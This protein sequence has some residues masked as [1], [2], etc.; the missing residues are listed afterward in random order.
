LKP[1]RVCLLLFSLGLA[2]C[3]AGR[4]AKSPAPEPP[5]A[6]QQLAEAM[7]LVAEKNWPQALEALRTIIEGKS[8]G[9]LSSDFRYKA[10]SAAGRVA[11]YHGP[12]ELGYEYLGRVVALPQ[13]N[14]VDW[15]ERLRMA[16]KLGRKADSI[17]TLTALIRRWP[18]RAEE[19][20][21]DYIL[22]AVDDA[23]LSGHAAA[24]GLL[25]ALNAA[26]WKLKWDIEPSAAWRDLAL[27]LL[28]NKR[29][30][31][32]NE[33]AHHVTDAYVLIAMRSDRRFDAVVAANPVQFDIEAAADRE[34][35]GRQ[36]AAEK[37][38]Q[39]LKLRFLVIDSLLR[40]QHYE[41]ALAASDSILLD[42]RSTNYPQRLY[43]DY[44]DERPWFLNLRSIALQRVGRWDEAV[45]QLNA[46]SLLL[47]KY[48]G[49]VNE[50]INLAYLY[51][52]LARPKD[53]LSAIGRLV[54]PTSPIGTMT[55][56]AVRV[57]AF[58]QLGDSK[59][60]EHSLRYLRSH[61][62]DFPGAYEVALITVNQLDRAASELVAELFDKDQRQDALEHLQHYAP[63]PG[64][65]R[66][67]DRE[68]RRRAVI[69]R[70][71]VQA[72]IRAVGRVETYPLEED[73]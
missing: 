25:E 11:I 47:E 13:S 40:Q 36:A 19:L 53:A 72:A 23:E 55:K 50:L 28:E 46:A 73:E 64:T 62:A 45:A 31:E 39:S 10:L 44:D 2:A 20:N 14:Y 69:A 26:H 22:H 66:H 61:R 24:I 63:T 27:L 12:P 6:T 3:G 9:G 34:F 35:N 18:D 48:S 49:N 54:A 29:F 7:E 60:V 21:A 32:A 51:C 59:Q 15:L 56:E 38:P 41:A 37:A 17:G 30:A 57:D 5:A 8:F 4:L 58:Y 16:D 70:P 33:V 43:E 68:A 42:I 1:Y 65:Q 71:E 67:M 52:D